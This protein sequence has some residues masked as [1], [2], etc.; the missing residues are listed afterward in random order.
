MS[1]I[2]EIP[3]VKSI[4]AYIQVSIDS[5]GNMIHH[6]PEPT[7]SAV[8]IYKGYFTSL[9]EAQHDQM[10]KSLKGTKTKIYPLKITL[11]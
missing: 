5:F 7:V 3:P 8:S 4:V 6:T 1:E 2:E 9:E 11:T 10:L